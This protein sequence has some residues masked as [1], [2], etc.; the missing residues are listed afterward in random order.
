M[1]PVLCRLRCK[2]LRE[3]NALTT[4]CVNDLF[5]NAALQSLGK[6]Q[7]TRRVKLRLRGVLHNILEGFVAIHTPTTLTCLPR[8]RR[9]TTRLNSTLLHR[10]QRS[11]PL[12]FQNKSSSRDQSLT[13]DPAL[14]TR[15]TLTCLLRHRRSTTRLNSTLLRQNLRSKPLDFQS[16]SS[17]RDPIVE[18]RSSNEQMS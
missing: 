10:N 2:R 7:L 11:K 3:L 14:H 6:S 16:K 5:S 15:S 17:S 8:H 12:D 9:S 4:R 13:S 1:T 18:L